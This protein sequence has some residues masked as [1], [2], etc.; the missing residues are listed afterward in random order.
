MVVD[1]PGLLMSRG[2]LRRSRILDG[3]VAAE[4]KIANALGVFTEEPGVVAEELGLLMSLGWLCRSR[5]A[6]ELG[7][8]VQEP[9]LL[10]SRGLLQR[11]WGY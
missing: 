9:G 5:V 2:L 3:V 8:V 7:V 11:S 1:E 6:N 10:I 4:P